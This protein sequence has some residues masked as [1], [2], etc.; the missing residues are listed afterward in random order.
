[1]SELTTAAGATTHFRACVFPGCV[2]QDRHWHGPFPG[3]YENPA[4]LDGPPIE[5]T[6]EPEPGVRDYNGALLQETSVLR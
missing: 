2:S 3:G 6:T 5:F 4:D 1:M